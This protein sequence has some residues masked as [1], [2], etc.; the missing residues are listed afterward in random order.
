MVAAIPLGRMGMPAEV[1]ETVAFLASDD[2]AYITGEVLTVG[3]G[4]SLAR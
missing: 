1:A 2:S 4:R 3:G